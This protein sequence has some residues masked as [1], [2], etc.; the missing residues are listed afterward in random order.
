[1]TAQSRVLYYAHDHGSGHVRHAANLATSGIAQVTVTTA[2][3]QAAQ[4][5]PPATPVISLPS[6][7]VEG[8]HQPSESWLHYTPTGPIVRRRFAELLAAAQ[9]T[10]P[11][12]VVV[13][14]SVETAL[15][16]RLA[17]YRVLHRRMHG[18]RIDAAH[19]LIYRESH[20]L[21]AHY[22]AALEDPAWHCEFGAKTTYLGTPDVTDRLSHITRS[23]SDS[24]GSLKIAVITGTGGGGVHVQ[25]LARA[26]HQVPHAQWHVYG[27]VR[28]TVVDA[29]TELPCPPNLHL[30]GWAENT[31]AVLEAA[32]VVVVS[33][34]H[35]AV[36]DAV[37]ACRPVVL[38]PETRPFDEQL[39]FARAC[40]R[41]A[42]TPWCAWE[43]P[44]ADWAQAITR[45][46]AEPAAADR[47]AQDL[48][49]T[50]Q[51]YA[52]LWRSALE[53]AHTQ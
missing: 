42:G 16:L 13:D 37:R 25:D 20:A 24:T 26:A 30:K 1:M 21:F 23:P 6:D 47:L 14:V 3:P 32:D 29:A 12:A 8:H 33:A 5:L 45:A 18:D 19:Q 9:R 48:F 44:Q 46:V 35:N 51:D 28:G 2:H 49:T 7:I 53:T 43:D 4:L 38:A 15:F 27:M 40:E 41:A 17:G 52:D 39:A 50:P 22:G 11:D 34:G 31:A 10:Q 36:V